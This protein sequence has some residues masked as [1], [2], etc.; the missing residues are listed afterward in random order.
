[1]ESITGLNDVFSNLA[2][3]ISTKS[4]PNGDPMGTPSICPYIL[5][6]TGNCTFSVQGSNN[7]RTT[8]TGDP[9]FKSRNFSVDK[10]TFYGVHQRDIGE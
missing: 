9:I 3:K 4:G 2:M 1:M 6:I 10:H 7:S 8:W 5:L